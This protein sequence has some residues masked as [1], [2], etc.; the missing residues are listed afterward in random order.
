[1][2]HEQY[3]LEHFRDAIENCYIQPYFQPVFRSVT[4]KVCS[5]EAL[6]RWK[7]PQYGIIPPGNFIP[8]L[9]SHNLI[10]DLDLE[11]L[12]QT[13]MFYRELSERGTLLHSFSVNLSRYDFGYSDLFERITGILREYNVPPSAIKLEITES[14]M[15]EDID[16]FRIIFDQFHDAGFSIWIDD[17]GSAYSS[18]NVLQNYDFD[19]IKFDML[20]LRNFTGKSRQVLASLINM[21]KSLNIHTLVEGIETEEQEVFLRSVGCEIMQGFHFSKPL[22]GEEMLKSIEQNVFI[23]ESPED[24]SYWNRIGRLNFLSPNPLEEFGTAQSDSSA[25][26]CTLCADG[27]PLALLECSQ[28]RAFYVYV[29]SAYMKRVY[30]LGYPSVEALEHAFNDKQSDQYLMMKKMVLDAVSTGTVQEVDYVNND[31]YY[32]VSARCIAR[33]EDRAM[34]AMQLRI[35]DTERE[36]KTAREMLQYGNA[37]FSTYEVVTLLYPDRSSA[38]R[39]YAADSIPS[40][41][42]AG[43]LDE[44]IH[45]FCESEIVPEEQEKYL[46]FFDLRTLAER[47]GE[48]PR[49]FIQDVFRMK[50][51]AGG[52][53][54]R[55]I[56]ISKVPSSEETV[57]IYTIQTLHSK[58]KKLLDFIQKEHPEVLE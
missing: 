16:T 14:I 42:Q 22:P 57:F 36:I 6:A 47:I 41:D 43:S 46:R 24:R 58:E 8:V 4:G 33:K 45:N 15:L 7:D 9:E 52:T 31:V 19:V 55:S 17:F 53:P 3:I 39:I 50:R 44:S 49:G 21:A 11:I 5:A 23:L 38:S 20:F 37:L 26:D 56:R 27:A 2:I 34:L 1:M 13:C 35:F 30:E 51:Y 12:R 28:H 29:S 54:W 48:S 18:L 40:Y 32:K 25:F 10:C